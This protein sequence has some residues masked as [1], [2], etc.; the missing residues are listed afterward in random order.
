MNREEETT[1]E[2]TD[3]QLKTRWFIDLGW[4]QQ[5]NRSIS[6]L[7]QNSL[8]PKCAKQLCTERKEISA[9]KLLAAIEGCCSN[10]P[11]FITDR[12]PIMA[13]IFRLF[14]ANGNQPLDLEELGKRLSERHGGDVY[15]TSPEI[16]FRL[17]K[18]DRYYGLQQI[19][20]Q[21]T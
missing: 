10:S 5:N 21:T 8:C 9:N 18:H 3:D 15:R 19:R 17:L 1:E 6:A 12:L 14:L 20:E 13:G 16:L 7:A 11:D 4:Y 2:T